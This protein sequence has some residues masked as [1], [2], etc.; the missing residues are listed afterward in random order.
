M[1]CSRSTISGS[2]PRSARQGW[3]PW[4]IVALIAL[5]ACSNAPPA[6]QVQTAPLDLPHPKVLVLPRPDPVHTLPVRWSIVEGRFTLDA[7]G[8]ENLSRNTAEFL[9]WAIEA[10]HQLNYYGR[11]LS[12]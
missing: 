6:L 10:S 8:Y 1:M 9:R 4:S 2:W 5:A 3:S 12:K 7:Q 11:E